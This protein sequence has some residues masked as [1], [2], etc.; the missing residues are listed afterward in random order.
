MRLKRFIK[1]LQFRVGLLKYMLDLVNTFVEKSENSFSVC[2]LTFKEQGKNPLKF[3]SLLLKLL[4][5]VLKLVK[6]FKSF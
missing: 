6:T 5:L 4:K 3:L 1:V 2:L